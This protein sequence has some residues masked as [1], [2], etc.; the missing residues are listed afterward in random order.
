M[1]RK[2]RRALRPS[3][4][5]ELDGTV[6]RERVTPLVAYVAAALE[7]S[8][9]LVISPGSAQ[10]KVFINVANDLT[11]HLLDGPSS[12]RDIDSAREEFSDA[13]QKLGEWQREEIAAFQKETAE[14]LLEL[15]GSARSAL[16][17]Q[18]ETLDEFDHLN[19][20]LKRAAS[21]D[22]IT[23]FREIVCDEIKKAGLIVEI[24]RKRHAELKQELTDTMEMME[25]KLDAVRGAGS[26]DYLTECAS[27]AALDFYLAAICKK[28][29]VEQRLYSIAMIDLDDFKGINDL[30]GHREG[31]NALGYFVKIVKRCLPSRAF[32]GRYGGDE[33]V[34]VAS[35][36]EE[37]LAKKMGKLLRTV[38][39]TK[40]KVE[41]VDGATLSL[42]ASAGV[43]EIRERD[44]LESVLRRADEALFTAKQRGKGRVCLASE[45]RVA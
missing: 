6:L 45:T 13:A 15:I 32:V 40:I 10:S 24:Q 37:D 4:W 26:K 16:D 39:A 14:A 8:Q 34:V 38:R 19:K 5:E 44:S 36:P 17:D 30:W 28:A 3:S 43:T 42:S 35:M 20:N 11:T 41:G 9:G 21:S 2:K 22:D 25:K 23:R 31:D 7:A 12:T 1:F 33:F 29:Q 18:D 27:R